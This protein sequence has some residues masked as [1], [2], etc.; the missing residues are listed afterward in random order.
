MKNYIYQQYFLE[1]VGKPKYEYEFD[2][3]KYSMIEKS[4]FKKSTK[5]KEYILMEDADHYLGRSKF[6]DIIINTIKKCYNLFK[7]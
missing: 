7:N 1:A 5:L 3:N 4:K 6:S 2:W